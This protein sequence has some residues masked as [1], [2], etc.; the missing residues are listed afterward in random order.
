MSAG[1]LVSHDR[2]LLCA[3]RAVCV[4]HVPMHEPRQHSI[5]KQL[6]FAGR[7]IT[8]DVPGHELVCSKARASAA[9][10]AVCSARRVA[11]TRVHACWHRQWASALP[12][13]SQALR[14]MVPA[15]SMAATLNRTA[16]AF[17]SVYGVKVRARSASW[18]F[19]A[20]YA[21]CVDTR[22][23]GHQAAKATGHWRAFGSVPE[24]VVCARG[25]DEVISC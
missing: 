1:G 15:T 18:R 19:I 17:E 7:I 21:V 14:I 10:A 24:W 25:L 3:R 13:P 20:P 12:T 4:P 11:D 22:H 5:G 16:A 2:A 8:K 23:G 9:A 6:P